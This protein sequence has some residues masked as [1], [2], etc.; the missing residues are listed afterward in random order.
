MGTKTIKKLSATTADAL[1][2]EFLI[3]VGFFMLP[4]C[5]LGFPSRLRRPTNSFLLLGFCIDWAHFRGELG[6][7]RQIRAENVPNLAPF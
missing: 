2:L 5:H 7:K 3:F 4:S 6:A 1:N